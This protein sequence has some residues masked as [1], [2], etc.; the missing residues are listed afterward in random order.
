MRSKKVKRLIAEIKLMSAIINENDKRCT[1]HIADDANETFIETLNAEL[2]A[3]IKHRLE[4]ISLIDT[5]RANELDPPE[6]EHN[7]NDT[8]NNNNH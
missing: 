4:L 5:T 8:N 1:C 2:R 7:A 6:S 3:L